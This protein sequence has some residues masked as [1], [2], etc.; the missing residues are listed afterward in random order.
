VK[1]ITP[2]KRSLARYIAALFNRCPGW[3]ASLHETLV[4][5]Q[6]LARSPSGAVYA[7]YIQL[8]EAV[9][10]PTIEDLLEA[11]V[12]GQRGVVVSATGQYT[13]EALELA[14]ER[15]VLT[16]SLSQLDYLVLAAELEMSAPLAR[17][18]LEIE[19]HKPVVVELEQKSN[20]TGVF[21]L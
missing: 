16:W 18:G 8:E 13:R 4:E 2:Q 12:P 14:K 10:K 1:P 7:F 20:I 5:V 3:L 6:V 19:V 21:Y 9:D 17:A 15:R 11:L